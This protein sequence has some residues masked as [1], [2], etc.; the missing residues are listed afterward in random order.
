MVNGKSKPGRDGGTRPQLLH[1]GACALLV[2]ACVGRTPPRHEPAP[3]PLPMCDSV[4]R[5][6]PIDTTA[7]RQFPRNSPR[8]E[9]TREIPGGF[10]GLTLNPRTRRWDILVVDT[11]QV[12]AA[13]AALLRMHSA[14]EVSLSHVT[15]SDLEN[16]GAEQVVWSSAELRD[17]Y[18][19]LTPL[20]LREARESGAV[21]YGVG[22][23][24]NR[25]MLNV[26]VADERS[27]TG[28]ERLLA[29][30]RV[31]CRLVGTSLGGPYVTR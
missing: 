19:F 14:G 2:I 5:L 20:L 28:V 30:M 22:I 7:A 23:N 15:Q 29:R 16:A 4:R 12:V 3:T 21:V 24:P 27:R 13:R 25:S 11:S 10:A 6:A 8:V 9:A 18:R 17:W 26:V 31:P 1:A